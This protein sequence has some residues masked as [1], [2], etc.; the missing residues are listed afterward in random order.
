MRAEGNGSRVLTPGGNAAISSSVRW[1]RA[2]A[3]VTWLTQCAMYAARTLDAA[4]LVRARA[5]HSSGAAWTTE[6][7]TLMRAYYQEKDLRL[8]LSAL[9]RQHD[10]LVGPQRSQK[11]ILSKGPCALAFAQE[12]DSQKLMEMLPKTVPRHASEF[13]VLKVE[14]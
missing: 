14:I 3:A 2:R 10:V 6:K 13:K 4:Q 8:I 1:T 12:A 9:L 5:T 11:H 7:S